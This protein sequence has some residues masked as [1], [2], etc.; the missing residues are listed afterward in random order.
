MTVSIA[1]KQKA[2]NNNIVTI[3][4]VATI[5]IAS[6][7]SCQKQ[8]SATNTNNQQSSS[9]EVAIQDQ[10]TTALGAI[11]QR[12]TD[13]PA[14]DT[15]FACDTESLGIA[16]DRPWVDSDGT[17]DF[18]Q[19][20]QV[21]GSVLWD[22]EQTITGTTERTIEGNG[23]P[24]H[25]TGEYPVGASSDAYQYDRNPN[26]ISELQYEYGLPM[27]PTAA[28]TPI[29][30]P[31]GTIGIALSGA[32][33]YNPLDADHRDAVANEIFDE[34]EG[35]PQQAGQ[36]H[37]HHNSPCFDVGEATEHS[38][39]IGYAL[40][41]FGIYG[42]RDNNGTTITNAELDECHGHTGTTPNNPN[43]EVYHYHANEEFPYFLGC[44]K[45]EPIE[46]ATQRPLG[47]PPGR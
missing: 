38:P 22:S 4:L 24:N 32:A 23:L 27:N 20:P 21:E 35:H 7:F 26:S 44:F 11:D 37:Y 42:P 36:Y 12:A 2:M 18:L 5:T 19:K 41:G 33:I 39:L 14:R 31:M 28:T 45:G 9:S 16:L 40:D 6:G 25:Q 43:E 15:L 47:P 10:A 13:Q 29:C 8:R 34:C 1:D 3:L 17:I 30:L 46:A